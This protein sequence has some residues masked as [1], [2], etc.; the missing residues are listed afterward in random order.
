MSPQSLG[1]KTLSHSDCVDKK[2]GKIRDWGGDNFDLCTSGGVTIEITYI[3]G[4]TFNNE[5]NNR[6]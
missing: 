2:K 3:S 5:T 1:Q 6:G 4:V